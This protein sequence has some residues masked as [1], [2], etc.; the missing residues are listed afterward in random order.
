MAARADVS[1]GPAACG[2]R[3]LLENLFQFYVYD[4]SE[5][6]ALETAGFAFAADGRF[7]SYPWFDDY[8]RDPDRWPLLIRAA[9][10]LAGFAL[11]NTHSHRG[12]SV[13][14]NM[15]EFFVARRYRRGGIA[16]AALHLILAAHPGR[17]EVAV[18]ERNAA[19]L[20]FWPRAIAAAPNVSG[21]VTVAGDGEHWR[22]PI[23]CFR[24]G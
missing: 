21:F 16:T 12:G 5:F 19:A 14:R 11:V 24:A 3:A 4:F 8:W 18:G 6:A 2:E 17:W 7:A 15:A 9:G 1:V 10:E 20:A 13:E 23:H 22:G